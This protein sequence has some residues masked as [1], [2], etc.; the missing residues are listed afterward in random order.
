[1][2]HTMAERMLK[3]CF[4]KLYAIAAYTDHNRFSNAYNG[5]FVH[6]KTDARDIFSASI[7]SDTANLD[8]IKNVSPE[9]YIRFDGLMKGDRTCI[10][11]R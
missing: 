6:F 10:I 9:T 5:I 8:T 2:E 4:E 7:L 11:Q 3:N 1:M